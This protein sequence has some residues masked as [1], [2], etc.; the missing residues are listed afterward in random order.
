MLD[1]TILTTMLVK[2]ES[3]KECLV[4]YDPS[5]KKVFSQDN[6]TT[7]EI[8][9]LR[10]EFQKSFSTV[11]HVESPSIMDTSFYE[12]SLNYYINQDHKL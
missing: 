1:I 12:D 7:E 3:G 4:H 6:L 10:Q 11:E 2:F 9:L 8:F 5:S